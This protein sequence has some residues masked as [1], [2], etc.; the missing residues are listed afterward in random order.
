MPTKIISLNDLKN[1]KNFILG[2]GHFSTIHPGHIRYLK[3][4]K[5]LG[6]YL[7]IALKGDGTLIE[8]K[9]KYQFSQSER[10]EALS[11]L[12]IADALILLYEDEIDEIVKNTNPKILILGKQFEKKPEERISISIKLLSKRGKS[13]LFHGGEISYSNSELLTST[14]NEMKLKR[15]KAFLSAC[16][17]HSLSQKDLLDSMKK[18]SN[19]SLIVIGDTIVDR[20]VACE[21]LGMSAEAPV[22]VVKELQNRDFCGGAAIVASHIKSLGAKCKLIS[23]IGDDHYGNYV[24]EKLVEEEIADGLI[25]DSSRPTTFKK[26]YLVE[27]QKLFR[28]TRLEQTEVKKS[29]EDQIINELEISAKKADGIVISDFVYGVITPNVLEKIDQLSKKY[30][31]QLFGDLQCSSQIG[32]ILKFKNLSLLCPNEREA[33]IAL[34]EKDLDLELISHQIIKKTNSYNLIMKLASEG[35]ILYYKKNQEIFSQAFPALS[36]N[37]ID[38]TGAGDSLLAVMAV[39]LSISQDIMTTS[40]IACCMTSL[41]VEKLGN[42][43]IKYEEL[44]LA[45]MEN[46]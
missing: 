38:V 8:K 13:V 25:I 7:V 15:K 46:L 6:S 43:P 5:S 1:K 24:K 39:G 44:R 11:M 18:W 29:I 4:A 45:I 31:L 16:K 14:E 22:L 42:K 21:A 3:H 2:Y 20:Y 27:N 10:A 30:N 34:H 12:D 36:T 41:A 19:S 33:R 28:V 23:V 17:R 26:R 32:S 40:A 35:F 37:P 9:Y